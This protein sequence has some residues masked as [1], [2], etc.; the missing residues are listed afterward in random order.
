[1]VTPHVIFQDYFLKGRLMS[2]GTFMDAHYETLFFQ[3]T[4]KNSTVNKWIYSVVPP[5]PRIKNKIPQDLAHIA[6]FERAVFFYWAS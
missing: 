5:P 4:L 3:A 1:M 6:V 2:I